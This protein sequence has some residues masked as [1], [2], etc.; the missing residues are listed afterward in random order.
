MKLLCYGIEK[1]HSQYGFDRSAKCDIGS[2]KVRCRLAVLS[3]DPATK[4]YILE[5]IKIRE[6]V[7]II[8][9]DFCQSNNFILLC[10]ENKYFVCIC[11]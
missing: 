9:V 10:T 4:G 6:Q 3:L 7:E 5:F 11:I 1:Y 2:G 8:S